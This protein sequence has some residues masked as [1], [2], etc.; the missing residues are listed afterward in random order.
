MLFQSVII[1][2]QEHILFSLIIISHSAT[3]SSVNNGKEILYVIAQVAINT[4]IY[5]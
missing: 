1:K 5:R 4:N 3:N 2:T